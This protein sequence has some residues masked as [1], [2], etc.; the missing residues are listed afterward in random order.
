MNDRYGHAAGD[1]LLLDVAEVLRANTRDVDLVARVGGDE[2]VLVCPDLE[3]PETLSRIMARLCHAVSA[4]APE[5]V[6]LRLSVGAAMARPGLGADDLIRIADEAMYR[7]KRD[8]RRY[9]AR[10]AALT[11]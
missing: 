8:G 2:F 3:T 9:G 1:Q 5:G 6:A 7:V 10:A 11:T 4:L